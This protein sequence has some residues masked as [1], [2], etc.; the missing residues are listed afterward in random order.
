MKRECSGEKFIQNFNQ[1]NLKERGRMGNHQHVS[2]NLKSGTMCVD[3]NDKC[4]FLLTKFTK[5]NMA[6]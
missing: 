1:E 3:I 4:E 2:I 6:L 5:Q